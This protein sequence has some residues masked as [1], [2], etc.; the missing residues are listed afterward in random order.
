[1]KKRKPSGK[2]IF[3]DFGGCFGAV[4]PKVILREV[5]SAFSGR[6][7]NCNQIK[8]KGVNPHQRQ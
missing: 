8:V 5:K 3:H 7:R 1:M 2:S 4:P 6:R